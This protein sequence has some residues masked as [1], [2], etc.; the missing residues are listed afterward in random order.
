MAKFK[1][2]SKFSPTQ[3]IVIAKDQSGQKAATLTSTHDLDGTKR[4]ALS[5]LNLTPAASYA[6]IYTYAAGSGEEA[7]AACAGNPVESVKREEQG[8]TQ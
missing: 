4:L 1:Q 8:V 3:Y 7:K 2:K 5:L 6:D